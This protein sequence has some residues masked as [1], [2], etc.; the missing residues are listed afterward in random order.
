MIAGRFAN[1]ANGR[2]KLADA[3]LS[4]PAAAHQP[5]VDAAR[6]DIS[7]QRG[8]RGDVERV[9]ARGRYARGTNPRPLD[10]RRHQQQRPV[11][12]MV[13]RIA[14]NAHYVKGVLI[15]Q[16]RQSDVLAGALVRLK[17]NAQF[18]ICHQR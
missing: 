9:H 13:R 8:L 17:R 14:V 15:D 3:V 10:M 2:V 6:S 16:L 1:G 7:Q 5:D 18:A 11:A 4:Q 12:G